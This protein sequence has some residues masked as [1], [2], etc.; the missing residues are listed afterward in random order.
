MDLDKFNS[1]RRRR[2]WIL[3]AVPIGID[4]TAASIWYTAIGNPGLWIFAVLILATGRIRG[5]F[6]H[7]AVDLRDA[8]CRCNECKEN[9]ENADS[10]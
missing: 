9:A 10:P 5:E 2:V 3:A 1:L 4:L 7:L 8:S 6:C